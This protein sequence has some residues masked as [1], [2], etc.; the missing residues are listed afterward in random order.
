LYQG[1]RVPLRAYMLPTTR[2]EGGSAISATGYRM[3]SK[4]VVCCEVRLVNPFGGV[5]TPLEP[6]YVEHKYY[7]PGVGQVYGRGLELVD[8]KTG[9]GKEVHL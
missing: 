5:R 4:E 7:A 2:Q 6:S 8:V 3:N 9:L 1:L